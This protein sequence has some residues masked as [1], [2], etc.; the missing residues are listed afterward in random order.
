[1]LKL[2]FIYKIKYFDLWQIGYLGK[3]E[4]VKL[5]LYPLIM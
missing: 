5:N 3:L 1:M 4:I 2:T